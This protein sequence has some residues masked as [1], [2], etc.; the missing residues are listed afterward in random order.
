MDDDKWINVDPRTR[1]L[2]LRF[3]VRGFSRQFYLSTGLRDTK[4]NRVIVQARRDVIEAD[5]GLGEFD[6]TLERYKFGSQ[7]LAPTV[8][9]PN[10]KSLGELWELFTEF[11]ST[12]VE[13]TTIK[14]SYAAIARYIKR[15]PTQELDRAS[16]IRDWLTKNTTQ[17]MAWHLLTKFSQCCEWA[18]DS[19]LITENPFDKL[20]IPKPRQKSTD[21]EDYLAFTLEQRDIIINAFEFH[22]RHCHYTDLVKF[23]FFTGCRP[24]EAF[25][26]TWADVSADCCRISITKSRNLHGILKGTKNGKRRIFP[27]ARGSKVQN[28]LLTVRPDNAVASELI[29]RS[30]LGNEMTGAI[31][32]NVWNQSAVVNNGHL[33][34]YPGV[35]RQLAQSRKI[36]Y[37]LKPYATRHTFATWAIATGVTP[38]KVALWIGDEVQTVLKYYC[39]PNVVDAECPDF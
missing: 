22:E 11:K 13:K 28:L 4:R 1:K 10:T 23:L 24:G 32:N 34:R 21:S 15:F 6:H 14:G 3:R 17:Y 33:C 2:S 25:A 35:V 12:M 36:P 18:K 37:Y 26:L 31:L 19:Q 8:H 30:R 27:A 7:R 38:E 29:F 5:I 9:I 16:S 39:H 20:K